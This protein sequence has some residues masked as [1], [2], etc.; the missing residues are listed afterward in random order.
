MIKHY[1]GN[2]SYNPTTGTGASMLE[3]LYP[4]QERGT[5]S[6][7]PQYAT[8][9]APVSESEK[10]YGTMNSILKGIGFLILAPFVA[11]AVLVLVALSL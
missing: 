6:Y 9:V 4:P 5:R 11:F 3:V 7:V 1:S 2:P 8:P 10:F